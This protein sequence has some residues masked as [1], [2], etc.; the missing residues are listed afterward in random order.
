[1]LTRTYLDF[2]NRTVLEFDPAAVTS[3]AVHR[4]TETVEVVKRDDGWALVKPA[5]QPGDEQAVQDV[6]RQ[7]TGKAKAVAAYPAKDRTPFGLEPPAAVVTLRLPG[8]EGKVKDLVLNV[9]K[10][11]DG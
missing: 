4:G 8:A 1:E 3:L 11:A 10:E 5:D 2:V 7:L 6:L 9:G